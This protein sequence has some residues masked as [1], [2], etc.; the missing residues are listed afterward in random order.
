MNV[1]V[2]R[3]G[4]AEDRDN[5]KYPND[6]DRPLTREGRLKLA[7]QVKGLNRLGLTLDVMVS[8]PLLRAAQ[9][10]QIVRDGL[11]SPGEQATSNVLVP[12]AHP[13]LLLEELASKHASAD[14]VMVVGHEPHLS[15]FVS[16]VVSGDPTA[17]I[18]LKKGA[19]CNLRL[20]SLDGTRCGWLEWLMTP[21][22]MIRLG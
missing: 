8:S 15:S 22:Q 12:E 18:R 16:M 6:D 4:V 1:Y 10:A 19:L 17:L 14:N 5:R 7:Q 21:D 13:Y 2:L 3:H 9:T 20:V 11:S